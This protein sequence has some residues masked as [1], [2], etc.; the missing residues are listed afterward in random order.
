ML[1][2]R[3]QEKTDGDT[4]EQPR[5]EFG[6]SCSLFVIELLWKVD[7]AVLIPKTDWSTEEDGHGLVRCKMKEALRQRGD[8]LR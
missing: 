5:V 6:R 4:Q 8:R 1:R 2:R 7:S 3:H